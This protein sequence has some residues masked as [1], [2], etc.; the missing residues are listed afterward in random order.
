M[1]ISKLLALALRH[2]PTALGLSLDARGWASVDDVLRGLGDRGLTISEEELE[3]VVAASDKQRFALSADGARIRANQG[4]SVRVDLGLS[5]AV[6]PEVLFHGTTTRF[7]DSIREGGLVAGA[8]THVHLSADEATART[9]ALRRRGPHVI[10]RVRAGDLHRTGALFYQSENG[11][12][13][14]DAVPPTHLVWP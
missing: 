6:P 12:W 5:P 2:E 1:R 3:Q 8:R 14:T 4:H 10:L 13:L 9:V 11:V 7:G